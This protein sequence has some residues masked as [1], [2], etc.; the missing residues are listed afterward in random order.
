MLML[1]LAQAATP[2]CP[3]RPVIPT[4]LA[5]WSVATSLE[6]AV[7]T[8]GI[9]EA[10]LP[11]GR[12]V[13]ATLPPGTDV[14]LPIVN[15]PAPAATYA[16]LFAFQVPAAGRYRVALGAGAWID[17]VANGV[18]LPSAAHGHGPDCSPIR[19]MVDYDLKPGRYLL[20]VSGGAKPNLGLLLARL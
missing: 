4:E 20:E 14:T 11:L 19:K 15:R 8:A 12:G 2:T 16:G 17:V 3:A 10:I 13:N 7:N 5:G 9:G 1:L 6:A 18:A